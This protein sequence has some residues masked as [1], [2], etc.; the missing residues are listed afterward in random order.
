MDYDIGHDTVVRI[1]IIL[2]VA[3]S[4]EFGRVVIGGKSFQYRTVCD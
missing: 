2:D 1:G 3:E 4:R